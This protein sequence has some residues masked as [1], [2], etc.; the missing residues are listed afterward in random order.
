MSMYHTGAP[1]R[2]PAR[3]LAGTPSP[4]SAPSRARCARLGR[5]VIATALVAGALV[6]PHVAVAQS[7]PQPGRLHITVV[8]QTRAVLPNAKVTIAGED[9][10]TRAAQ[11]QPAVASTVGVATFDRLTLG[12][13]TVVAEFP[14]FQAATVRDVRVRSGDNRRTVTLQL[15][16]IETELTV[17]R[18]KQSASLDP[19]GDAFS[20]VLTREQIAALPDDPDEM[21]QVLKA[22]APPGATIRVDGFTGGKLPP[23]SQI[24]SIRLPRLDA[25]AAQNHGGLTGALFIDIMTQPGAGPLRGNIDFSFLDDAFNARNALTPRKGDEQLR[26]FG[27]SLS[28]TIRPNKTSFSLS[29]GGASQYFSSNLFAVLPGGATRAE[30][31]RQPQSR[32]NVNARLDHALNRDHALKVVFDRTG[33]ELRDLG[34]GDYNLPEHAYTSDTATNMLRLSE[35]GALGRR[36]FTESRVQLRWSDSESRS[37]IEAPTIRVNDAFTSGGA[38][39]RGGRHDM[40]FELASD[41]D[42]VRGNHSWRT[43]VLLEGGR[44]R[45]DDISNYLG[46]YT[47]ASLADYE[48]GRPSTYTRRIGDP[49]VTYAHVQAGAYVQDDWRVRRSVLLSAGVRYEGQSHAGGGANLSPRLN[50]AWSPR[51]DGSLTFRGSYGY[52][53]DWIAGDIYKQTVLVDGYRQRE[54]NIRNPAFPDPGLDGLTP[55]TNRYLWSDA[56]ALPTANRLSAGV[57]RVLTPNMRMNVSYNTGWGR[58]IL[59]G[60]N[61]NAP[62]AGV[63]PDASFANVVQL[64]SDARTRQQSLNIGWN[65]SMLNRRRTFMFVNYTLAKNESNSSGP[66][67]LPAAGD[68]LSAEWG[69]TAADARHRI[70]ASFNTQPIANLTVA[71]NAGY[72]SA[73]PYNVTTGRDDN[74]DGVFNDRPAGTPR[75]SARGGAQIDLGGRVSYAW[76]FGERPQ[77]GGGLG[78]PG[79]VVIVGGGGAGPMTPAFGGGAADKRYRLE[80]YVSAQNLLNRTNYANYSGVM[81][82]PL[83]G[84][85]TSAG[86]ARRAQAGIRFGF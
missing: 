43:G 58:H 20:T 48:A 56:L 45:S 37:L 73:T 52:F 68:D 10:A 8:D 14:G 42:Y 67:S 72:R 5:F 81:T 29:A 65:V 12:R 26:Q 36:F 28:G 64:A 86:Q 16:K 1:P 35:N 47:F 33:A 18:D 57:D 82:S 13:Y 69:P 80:F 39:Q 50:V 62:I 84:Q 83:F 46:T 40:T 6:R 17:G 24:R 49:N 23:K 53:Y 79:Q 31:L 21:E 60:R 7:V 70:G 51:K 34:I 66:F 55:P 38:Q 2:T 71:L 61:L 3:S 32:T 19:R 63:R 4:H 27:T 85:P 76:G 77:T 15:Q 44:Y 41:L 54:L 22:M 25:F 74:G 78:G 9:E 30:A 11:L 75:N 59:R